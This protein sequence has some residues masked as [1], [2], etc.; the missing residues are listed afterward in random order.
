MAVSIGAL[1]LRLYHREKLLETFSFTVQKKI[2]VDGE[3]FKNRSGKQDRSVP[4]V[5][6]QFLTQLLT[7]LQA[8]D[9]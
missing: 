9:V 2:L 6:L 3:G 1:C 7:F 5:F 8:T 4:Q